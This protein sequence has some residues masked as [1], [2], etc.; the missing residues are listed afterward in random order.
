MFQLKLS[1]VTTVEFLEK[2]GRNFE[3]Q[4]EKDSISSLFHE[5][6]LVN[7]FSVEEETIFGI[8]K[9][10]TIDYFYILIL[11]IIFIKT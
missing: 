9:V 7:I 4:D 8:C 2:L 3:T 6:H 5:G 1:D 11:S 10:T